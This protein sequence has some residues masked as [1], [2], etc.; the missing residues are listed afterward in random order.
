MI[1]EKLL[2]KVYDKMPDYIESLFNVFQSVYKK[3]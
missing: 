2:S 3:S 1:E